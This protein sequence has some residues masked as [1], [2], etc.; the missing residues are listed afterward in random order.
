MDYA[1]VILAVLGLLLVHYA[2]VTVKLSAIAR[3][4]NE[5]GG[6]LRANE[7]V[8]DRIS[9]DTFPQTE[10]LP[11][12]LYGGNPDRFVELIQ[13][14]EGE[15]VADQRAQQLSDYHDSGVLRTPSRTDDE[16][17]G[18][19]SSIGTSGTVLLRH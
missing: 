6:L 17:S 7:S 12:A 18:L 15:G 16:A 11:Y 1:L 19:Q 3:R 10:A 4:N 8:S 14:L 9:A 13:H 5:S 2:W